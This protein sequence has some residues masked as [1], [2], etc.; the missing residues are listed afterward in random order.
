MSKSR[1]GFASMTPERVRQVAS[2]GG[3]KT[4]TTHN[5]A[6]IGKAGGQVTAKRGSSYFAKIGRMGGKAGRRGSAA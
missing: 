1:R 3:K 2:K 4:A 5:M 6:M